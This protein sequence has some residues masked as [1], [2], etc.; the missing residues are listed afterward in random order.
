MGASLTTLSE[1]QRTVRVCHAAAV[2]GNVDAADD[3]RVAWLQPVQVPAMA[4]PEGERGG[5]SDLR[6][7]SRSQDGPSL[8]SPLNTHRWP[9]HHRGM[10]LRTKWIRSVQNEESHAPSTQAPLSCTVP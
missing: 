4:D 2:V 6:C 10:G 5:C 9:W 8:G 3:E 7:G 1:P